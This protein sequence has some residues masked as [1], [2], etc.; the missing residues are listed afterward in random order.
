MSDLLTQLF[1]LLLFQYYLLFLILAIEFGFVM[2]AF[3]LEED[4]G[5]TEIEFSKL[6]GV[7]TE[8]E[9]TVMVNF[10]NM[11]DGIL[12]GWIVTVCCVYNS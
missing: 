9:L 6:N 7:M 11:D 4:S 1:T 12:L 8:V 10:A 3:E 5:T 2:T